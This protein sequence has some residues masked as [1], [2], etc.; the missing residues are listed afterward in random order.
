MTA[1][2]TG[3]SPAKGTGTVLAVFAAGA[4]TAVLLG[5]YGRVH[6]PTGET[7]LTAFFWLWTSFLAPSMY[8]Q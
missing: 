8:H 3:T 4:A 5:A 2:T 6:D 1:T 7:A